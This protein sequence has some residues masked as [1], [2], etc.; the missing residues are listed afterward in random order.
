MNKYLK[1]IEE[2][3]TGGPAAE[4]TR[5]PGGISGISGKRFGGSP[6]KAWAGLDTCDRVQA[7]A[8][9]CETHG[10]DLVGFLADHDDLVEK[11]EPS[12]CPDRAAA[13]SLIRT[14]REYGV[15]LHLDTDGTLVVVRPWRSLLTAL[16][17]HVDAVAVL[18][19]QRYDGTDS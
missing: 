8:C 3:E 5:G 17:A 18:L 6:K 13:K 1:M 19:A 11:T 2:L 10:L 4:S 9:Y 16:E 7:I 12:H 14:C 15:G